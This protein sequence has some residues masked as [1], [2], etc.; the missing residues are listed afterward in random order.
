[1]TSVLPVASPSILPTSRTPLIGRAAEVAAARACLLDE[2]VPLLTLTGPGGVGKTRLA[3]EIAHEIAGSFADGAVFVDLSPIR[4]PALVLPVIAQTIGVREGSDRPL[5]AQVT[6]FLKPRQL[7]LVLDN[8]EQVLDAAPDV[9]ALLASCPALQILATSRSPLRVRGEQLFPVPPLAL[10]DSAVTV[11]L[12]DVEAAAAVALFVQRARAAD[13][14]FALAES[15]AA[16]V[17][18]ACARL[19]GLPLAIELAAARLR[20]LSPDALLALLT[21]RLRVLTGGARDL[22]DRQRTLRDAIAWSYDLLDDGGQALFRRL[23]VFAGGFD[24]VAA[25]AVAADDPLDV[26][27]RLHVLADQS[28]LVAATGT[29]SSTR[30]M[31]LETVREFG[32]ERLAASGEDEEA[33]KAHAWHFLAVAEGAEPHLYL[34]GQEPWLARLETE[35]DNLRAALAWLERAGDGSAMQR[36]AGALNRFWFFRGHFGEGRQWL[37]R[38]LAR[39]GDGAPAAL[40]AKALGGAGLL[41]IFKG[42][43]RRAENLIA[44]SLAIWREL[45]DK[46][47]T[48]VGANRLGMACTAQERYAEAV[49]WTEEALALFEELGDA[50]VSAAPQATMALANLGNNAY[51]LGEYARAADRYS[52]ALARQRAMGFTWGAG[53][54]LACLGDVARARGDLAEAAAHYRES[55]DHWRAHRDPWGAITAPIGLADV[56]LAWGQPERATRLLAAMAAQFEVIGRSYF[57]LV[58]QNEERAVAA[59]RAALG[60]DVFAAAWAEGRV[61][62]FAAAVDEALRVGTAPPEPAKA[63]GRASTHGLSPRELE[64]LRLLAQR[65]TDPEI[66]EALFISRHTVHAHLKSIFGKLNATNRREAAAVAARLGLA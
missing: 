9:A 3:L 24:A 49:A 63:N 27:D 13:P 7:L 26:L 28:L 29:G 25:A 60:A 19:D 1:V 61:L 11:R 18:E 48:A 36:L 47:Q 5:V 65:Y 4:D 59:A 23:A 41:S 32:L 6:A 35:H 51:A 39:A 17:A 57:P 40:R 55:L 12:A 42:D 15:N 62:S 38:A 30:W 58:H 52:E 44:Q 46:E 53:I 14:S 10:P 34:P 31:Q 33:Q 8:C 2:A 22:P 21:R 64:V 54:S 37:E 43:P 45:G 50:A 56:A 20:T 66:A 16:A